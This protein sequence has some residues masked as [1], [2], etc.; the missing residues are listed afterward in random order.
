V[1]GCDGFRL[2][3]GLTT[4]PSPPKSGPLGGE[5]TDNT[6]NIVLV[7]V[8]VNSRA[9]S[10]P[11]LARNY[12]DRNEVVRLLVAPASKGPRASVVDNEPVA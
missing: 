3:N 12:L 8:Y 5:I 9:L 1:R 6:T 4:L 10:F 7:K 2:S 11:G